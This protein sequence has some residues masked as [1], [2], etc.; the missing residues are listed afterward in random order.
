M[1]KSTGFTLKYFEI[2]LR[3]AWQRIHYEGNSTE[4][5]IQFEHLPLFTMFQLEI[6]PMLNISNMLGYG[7]KS[8]EQFWI[9]R[10]G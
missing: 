5:K 4:S 9:S 7:Q 8:V 6:I 10:T 2:T 1:K 3:D